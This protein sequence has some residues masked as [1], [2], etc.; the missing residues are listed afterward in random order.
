MTDETPPVRVLVAP[1]EGMT[2]TEVLD[3]LEWPFEGITEIHHA[4]DIDR[5]RW[6]DSMAKQAGDL[7]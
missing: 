6:D 4:P 7:N 1:R 3:E 2:V 5:Q